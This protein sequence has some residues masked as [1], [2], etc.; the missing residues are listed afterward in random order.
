MRPERQCSGRI[1]GRFRGDRNGDEDR[2][3]A[4]SP[5]RQGKAGQTHSS[6]GLK[7]SGQWSQSVVVTCSTVG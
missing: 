2:S 6:F 3:R 1:W 5:V 7:T 4:V